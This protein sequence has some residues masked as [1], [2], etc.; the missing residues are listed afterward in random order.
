MID[1]DQ[2]DI[3]HIVASLSRIIGEQVMLDELDAIGWRG[4]ESHPVEFFRG[5][6]AEFEDDSDEKKDMINLVRDD[7]NNIANL[8]GFTL[9]EDEF[10]DIVP[11]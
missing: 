2:K 7:I 3:Q 1:M 6:L 9:R 4:I 11:R 8:Y 5:Y 10:E